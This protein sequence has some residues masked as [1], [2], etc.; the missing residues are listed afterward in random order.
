MTATKTKRPPR[1]PP[2]PRKRPRTDASSAIVEAVLHAS[3]LLLARDG[4]AGLTTNAVARV[5][6]VSVG[7]V[8]QYF[9]D[10]HAIVAELARD[11]E[12]RGLALATAH[13]ERLRD[14][15][16]REA[17]WHMVSVLLDPALGHLVTRRALLLEVP[18]AWIFTASRETDR[19]V[20]QMLVGFMEAH[21][22]SIRPGRLD[23]MAFVVLHAVEG[24]I[25]AA[26]LMD[27][28]LVR[29]EALRTE[30]FHLVWRYLAGPDQPLDAPA[31]LPT[32]SRAEAIARPPA[33]LR[34]RF[35]VER[36]RRPDLS[37]RAISATKRGR[38]TVGAILDG[39][40]R[41]LTM[42][43]PEALSVRRIAREAGTALGTLYIHF[44]NKEAVV[45]ALAE[46][47]E[48]RMRRR[49]GESMVDTRGVPLRD[50]VDAQVG[51]YAGGDAAELGLRRTLLFDVPRRWSEVA[52][53]ET[54]KLAIARVASEVAGRTEEVRAADPWL[55]AFVV[56]ST[57]EAVMQSALLRDLDWLGDAM[58]GELS[59]LAWR[60]LRA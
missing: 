58:Q 49:F 28:E 14:A 19:A 57:V 12:R 29:R 38:D 9:P 24:A 17:A 21:R 31:V 37:P 16:V 52:A 13:L 25:E 6:G 11:L 54:R 51:L 40:A 41:V 60:Y 18:R 36:S 59:E 35:E 48:R 20:E 55:A 43:G 4:V 10:K 34:A 47:S 5:A 39:A 26:L 42:E 1:S 30:L 27:T 22:A 33:S 32:T 53:T 23:R 7:S 8:Y 50:A 2:R 46:R 45:A 44:P 56:C 15:S 3:A